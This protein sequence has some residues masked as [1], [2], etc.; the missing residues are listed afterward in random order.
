[1]K[2]AGVGP[3][4]VFYRYLTPKW[5]YLPMSGEGAANGGGRFNRPGVEALYLSRSPQTALE[6]CKQ[7]ASIS[8][9]LTLAA[10]HVTLAEVVDLSG[11]Y[12]PAVWGAA[13]A[14]WDCD[15]KQ[16]A[17][18]DKGL[19]PSWAVSDTVIA[20]RRAGILFPSTRH[21]GGMNLVIF[22][23]NLSAADKLEVYDPAGALPKDQSSWRNV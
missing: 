5:A 9:P 17:R 7:G 3:D 10:Y 11:G 20:A 4:E 16:I 1:L 21:M 22:R 2:L 6:E 13:W 19:P 23:Q 18:I 12:D 8:P 14:N 15:W